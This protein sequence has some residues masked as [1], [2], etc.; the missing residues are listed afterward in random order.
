MRP[1]SKDPREKSSVRRRSDP[2]RTQSGVIES[3]ATATMADSAIQRSA[4]I[5]HKVRLGKIILEDL[6]KTDTRARLL[7]A[8][9]L[10]RDEVLLDGVLAMISKASARER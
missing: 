6:P 7:E 2:P 3:V 4:R 9:I 5:E 10:R 1:S 8:A